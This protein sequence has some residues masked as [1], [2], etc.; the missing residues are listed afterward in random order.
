MVGVASC[1]SDTQMRDSRQFVSWNRE[2]ALAVRST[3]G[4]RRD[5]KVLNDVVLG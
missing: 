1:W 5:R 4:T 3:V 2:R